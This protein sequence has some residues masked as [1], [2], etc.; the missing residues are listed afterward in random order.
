MLCYKFTFLL[1]NIKKL[2]KIFIFLTQKNIEREEDL[3]KYL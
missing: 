3:Q 1:N 2:I